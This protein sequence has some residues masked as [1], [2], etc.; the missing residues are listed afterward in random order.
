MSMC[1]VCLRPLHL[2]DVWKVLEDGRCLCADCRLPAKGATILAEAARLADGPRNDSYG[3]PREDF[4]RTAK[5]WSALLGVEITAEQVGLCM[6]GVKLSR[7]CHAPKR[8]NL[9]D[10]AGYARTLEKLEEPAL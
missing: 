7:H 1:V 10:I 9:V 6:I 4:T 5:I 8:D 3:H 2:P